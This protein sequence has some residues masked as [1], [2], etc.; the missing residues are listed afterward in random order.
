[1]A[2]V[3]QLNFQIVLS[4]KTTDIPTTSWARQR[5]QA[6]AYR[7]QAI[8]QNLKQA[9]YKVGTE[10]IYFTDH[11]VSIQIIWNSS[12][13]WQDHSMFQEKT[14]IQIF[15]WNFPI[16]K[17]LQRAKQK[18][19][20]GLNLDHSCF[21]PRSMF[22]KLRPRVKRK[23]HDI[24]GTYSWCHSFIPRVYLEFSGEGN[25]SVFFKGYI[26]EFNAK[27]IQLKKKFSI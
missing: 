3:Q 16:F 17:I 8:K 26:T 11:F 13:Q 10:S 4:T 15:I 2:S 7:G 12:Q 1:M 25:I 18:N 23:P 20:C 24:H 21:C 5:L 22:L 6:C 19:V 14:K 27:F 9:R